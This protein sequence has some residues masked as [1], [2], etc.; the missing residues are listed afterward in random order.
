MSAGTIALTNN[1]T[2]VAGTGTAFYTDLKPN[3]FIV[4]IV[5][6]MTYTL[7]IKSIESAIAL[8]LITA[9]GGPA[10][11]GL[12]WTAIPNATLVG[13]TAQVAS[14]VAK[15]I[16]GL[17]LDKAN[18]QQVFSGTDTITV[19]LPDGSTY[20]GPAW[21]SITTSLAG[22]AVKGTN[23]D[24]TSLTGLTTPL[25][26]E[27][28]GTGGSTKAT[29]WASIATYGTAAGT[30][31]QGNDSRLGTINDKSGGKLTSGI[32]FNGA[33]GFKIDVGQA[34]TEVVT[35]GSGTEYRSYLERAANSV[36]GQFLNYYYSIGGVIS[37][38]VMICDSATFQLQANGIGYS[39][40][41][42]QTFSDARIKT[43]KE[44]ITQPLEK[45]KKLRGYTWDR[46]DIDASGVGF[47]AQ[48]LQKIFPQAVS[49][50]TGS[51][52]LKDGSVVENALS[53][54]IAGASAAL[55]HEAILALMDRLDALE[56]RIGELETAK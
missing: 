11:T 43:K 22:K 45:M 1:S 6:G 27:Q 8:T 21:N 36:G 29:A 34:S 42:W 47:L 19:T 56:S 7:G 2:T 14:D 44:V 37:S 54:D 10:A 49:E 13:I 38:Y 5:G 53:I 35:T 55:H 17:N 20:T 50:S 24:I 28:G 39:S 31:A 32:T 23:G 4:V 46:L 16:R 48:E 9:Y 30:A 3:D 15:A 25:S 26:L 52:I 12:A 41:G 51:V 18:W 40:G 33:T